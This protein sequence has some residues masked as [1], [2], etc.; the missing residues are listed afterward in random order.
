MKGRRAAKVF[1]IK[2]KVALLSYDF[3]ID[4]E[5]QFDAAI[6]KDVAKK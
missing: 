4:G 5:L 3:P 6:S 2:S 1:S